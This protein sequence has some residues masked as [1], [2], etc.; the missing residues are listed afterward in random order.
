MNGTSVAP[1]ELAAAEPVAL[2]RQDDDR[3]ALGRLVGEARELRRIGEL[4]LVDAGKRKERGRLAVAERD[5]AGLVEEERRAVARGLDRAA[6]ERE[7]VALDEAVHPGDADR[8]E[9]RADRRRDQAD[10]QRDQHDDGLLRARVDGERL[11]GHDRDEED[12]GQAGEE[13]VERDLVRGLL[14][15]RALDER[16]H[17]VEEAL[18]GLRR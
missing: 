12:E 2:L 17:P 14:P 16:D 10:E 13:D 3:A 1:C 8:R 11:Q 9:Q 7:H 6:R 5:R 4:G 15:A 18:A